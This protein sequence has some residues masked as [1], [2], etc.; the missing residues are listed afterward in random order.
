MFY[1]IQENIYSFFKAFL[2]NVLRVHFGTPVGAPSMPTTL[3]QSRAKLLSMSFFT[4]YFIQSKLIVGI[5]SIGAARRGTQGTSP[6]P[7]NWKNCCRKMMLF[8]KALFLATTFPKIDKNSILLMNFYQ[9][10]SKFSQN[11]QT[12][13][14]LRPNARKINA[15]LLKFCW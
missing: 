1:E 14:I 12:I 15:G 6:P 7:R 11:F 5:L 2:K 4:S 9:K 3:T 10:I 13:S 8:P